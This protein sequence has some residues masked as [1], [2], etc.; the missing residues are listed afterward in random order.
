MCHEGLFGSCLAHTFPS[1]VNQFASRKKDKS[2]LCLD[3]AFPLMSMRNKLPP[4]FHICFSQTKVPPEKEMTISIDSNWK[5][6]KL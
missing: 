1:A 4:H 2:S 5:K 6:K 3:V